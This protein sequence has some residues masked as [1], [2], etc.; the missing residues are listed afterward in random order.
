MDRLFRNTIDCLA[1]VEELENSD[2]G[3]Q[4]CES[5]GNAA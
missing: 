2:V 4:L 3:I 5:G 1:T